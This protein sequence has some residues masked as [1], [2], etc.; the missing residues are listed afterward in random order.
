LADGHVVVELGFCFLRL[1]RLSSYT[2][3]LV[4]Y[5]DV[6]HNLMFSK[7]RPSSKYYPKRVILS[8]LEVMTS[9]IQLHFNNNNLLNGKESVF[10][11]KGTTFL[12]Q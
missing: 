7:G 3:G 5:L 2:L 11:T 6:L 12:T 1:Q 4:F 9:Q 10:R 8:Q